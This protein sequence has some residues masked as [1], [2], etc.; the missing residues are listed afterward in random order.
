MTVLTRRRGLAAA[1][2]AIALAAIVTGP[3][4]PA[5]AY[6]TV[7]GKKVIVWGARTPVTNLD[8]H[9]RYDNPH[10]LV[11]SMIYEPLIKYEGD[12]AELVP[13]IATSWE[14]SDDAKTWTFKL[15]PNAKFQNGDPIDAEAVRYSFA[16]ALQINKAV[17][18]MLA[19]VLSPEGVSVVDPETVKFELDVP[20]ASFAGFLPWWMIVNPKEIEPHAVDGDMGQA[21]MA[22]NTAGSG[23]F[24][25]AR[26]EQ[27]QYYYLQSDE[28]YWN[29]WPQGADK[30]PGGV[31]YRIIRE[32]SAQRSAL[33][34]GEVDFAE[35]LS[36]ADYVQLRDAPGIVIENNPGNS[37]FA[38]KFNTQNG[39]VADLNLRKAIA[40]AFPYES[41][42][43]LYDGDAI[44]M[45]SPFPQIV[46]GHIDVDGFPRQDL[47]KAKEYLAKSAYPDGGI[48]LNY[49][50]QNV[51]DETRRV[52]LLLLDALKPLNIEVNIVPTLWANMVSSAQ[53]PETAAH[54]TGL[55][56][57]TFS[58]DPDNVAYQFTK[59]AW[60]Q[61]FGI[62]FYDNPEVS[63]LIA[64][65]RAIASWDERAPMYAKV[66]E[67]ITADQPEVFGYL[68]N[69]K[70]AHRDAVKGFAF[71]PMKPAA[72]AD[73][74]ALWIED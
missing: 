54:M 9:Q 68:R 58:T 35:G 40:Y 51:N 48:T 56:T 10:H 36:Q 20:Y 59:S 11:Q 26:W 28:T 65:A 46:N 49:V 64:D 19:D 7:N 47:E 37:A 14:M 31:I 18:W 17:S 60:G 66:Q 23:P 55:F 25:I 33:Q 72:W 5:H 16:R 22:E 57:S 45:T 41:F 50:H 42:I 1:A 8:P 15:D 27:N 32:P 39:P 34:T 43:D 70:L 63:K 71:T 4:A 73:F 62:S 12:P 52:G 6:E 38:I 2:A 13:W 29:G 3:V 24:K 69:S 74:H 61:W 30:A 21:W 44:L 53:S 67:M